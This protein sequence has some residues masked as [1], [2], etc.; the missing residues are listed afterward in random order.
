MLRATRMNPSPYSI[1]IRP[2]KEEVY[3]LNTFLAHG[4]QVS[5]CSS[6][7]QSNGVLSIS[8]PFNESSVV[9]TSLQ[10]ILSPFKAQVGNPQMV[11][12]ARINTLGYYPGYLLDCMCTF[13][14]TFFSIF[15][16]MFKP[17]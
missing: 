3:L 12:D 6:I 17:M 8:S 4:S 11:V 16:S 2:N 10:F 7:D 14:C 15:C 13:N 5:K 9:C 1:L